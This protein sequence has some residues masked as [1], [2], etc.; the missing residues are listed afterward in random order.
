LSVQF[1]FPLRLFPSLVYTKG[2]SMNVVRPR[3]IRFGVFQAN[4]RLFG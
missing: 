4:L 1:P 2:A 3:V